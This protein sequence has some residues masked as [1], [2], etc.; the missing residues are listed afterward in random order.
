MKYL[1]DIL[2][3]VAVMTFSNEP[4]QGQNI[5][6]R[7]V[8]AQYNPGAVY[9]V[10]VNSGHTAVVEFGRHEVVESVALGDADNWLVETTA[11]ANRLVIKPGPN[12][13][14]TN[15]VVL[16]TTHTYAFVLSPYGPTE[17]FVLRFNYGQGTVQSFDYR[18]R[19]MRS[20]FP[21]RISDNGRTTTIFWNAESSLPAVFVLDEN[22]EEIT[23]DYRPIGNGL[24]VNGIHERYIFRSG[25]REATATRRIVR[26]ED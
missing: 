5:D 11:S 12:A 21:E 9:S 26:N 2:L 22:D 25:R 7:I 15:M 8:E 16:T 18:L 3:A 6:D 13:T 4:A 1:R 10:I 23:P 20:L 14:S 24:I 17:T 19:G